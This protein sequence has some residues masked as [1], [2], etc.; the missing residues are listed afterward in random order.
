MTG[1]VRAVLAALA[2]SAGLMAGACRSSE[3][4]DIET[5]QRVSVATKPARRGSIRGVITVT[6]TVK[7][8]PDGEQLVMAPEAARIVELPKAAGDVVHKG[9]LLVRFEIPS[10]DAEAAAKRSDVERAKARLD[11]AQA[12]EERIRGLFERGIAA[13][14]E[15]EDAQ[16]ELAEAKAGLTEAESGRLAASELAE[17]EV[18]RARFDG[19]VASRSHHPGE[20]VEAGGSDPILRVIDPHALQVEAGVPV[21]EIASV[22]VGASARIL[23]PGTTSSRRGDPARVLEPSTVVSRPASVDPATGTALVRLSLGAATALPDGTPVGVEI[24][25]EE[26]RNAVVVPAAA[27]VHEGADAYVFTVDAGSHAHRKTVSL[28][29]ASADEVEILS[30]LSGD[31][32]VVVK[33]QQALPDGADVTT[34]P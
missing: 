14:K 21:A 27:I 25:G 3:R 7:P 19:I 13:R 24:L 4:D 28:G 31:E 26:H 32:R 17:R 11:N 20:L 10:L 9:E 34:E 6:G 22:A 15:V 29:V 30:G 23:A 16:R 1:S 12:S 33:G 2:L 8:A 18:V 5:T